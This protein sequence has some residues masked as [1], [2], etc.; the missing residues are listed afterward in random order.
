MGSAPSYSSR[1]PLCTE[2]RMLM[3]GP[4][5]AVSPGVLLEEG[6]ANPFGIVILSEVLID[7]FL[8]PGLRHP[9][10]AALLSELPV[11]TATD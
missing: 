2:Q 4:R 8:T 5:L 10:Q 11:S 3:D 7:H 1:S 6:K 9:A